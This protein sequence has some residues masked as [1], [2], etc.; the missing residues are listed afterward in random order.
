MH[1]GET[2][3]SHVFNGFLKFL[4]SRDDPRAQTLRNLYV[5]KLIPILNPDG[6]KRGHYRQDARGVNLNRFYDRPSLELHPS[7]YASREVCLY[8]HRRG[9]LEFYLD[10]HAHAARRGCF[11]FGNAL[12]GKRQTDNVTYARLV[13]LNSAHF[14]FGN[15]CFS[16]RNMFSRD[17]RD[18]MSK[19]GSGRVG[20]FLAT[21]LTHV[22]TLECNYNSGREVCPHYS[23]V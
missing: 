23:G 1:P 2:P 12:E 16:E 10:L 15:C 7:I 21:N 8:H 6:V 5:F 4:L 14:D 19:E 22:Y 9:R 20:I 11:I 13:A 3:A 17:K 18:G